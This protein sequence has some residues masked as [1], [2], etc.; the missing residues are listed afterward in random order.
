MN[1]VLLSIVIPIYQE[2]ELL[3]ACLE[4][5]C[6]QSFRDFQLII[7]EDGADEKTLEIAKEFVASDKRAMLLH[8]PNSGV[9]VARNNGLSHAVGEYVYFVD[10]DDTLENTHCFERL[11][12]YLDRQRPDLVLLDYR[13]VEWR[14]NKERAKSRN[15]TAEDL[16]L[17]KND[18]LNLLYEKGIYPISVWQF[19]CRRELLTAHHI[20][21]PERVLS[22]DYHFCIDVH[23]YAESYG[24][25]PGCF[26]V[27]RRARAG[28][29]TSLSPESSIAG[30]L[31][32]LNDYVSKPLCKNYMG[33]INYV[34]HMYGFCFY[35]ISR[36]SK[37]KQ[38][39][40]KS[41]MISRSYIL[42]WSDKWNH[43][44]IYYTLHTIGYRFT[45]K[46]IRLVYLAHYKK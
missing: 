12:E 35:P 19:V 44:L 5:I 45:I 36:L 23:Y 1:R 27:Y 42:K 26:Y 31:L 14:N 4:S 40:L 21:F 24:Y 20:L 25:L 3:R 7:V 33:L 15:L 38:I 2:G 30:N 32:T 39:R 11:R 17:P 18:F 28:S 16:A 8:Q 41:E 37:A 6:Q 34:A 46:M 10:G 29:L 9:S 43:H 22:E 13:S